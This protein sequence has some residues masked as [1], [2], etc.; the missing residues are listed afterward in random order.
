MHALLPRELLDSRLCA[1]RRAGLRT[2]G[3][4]LRGE[5]FLLAAASQPQGG[6]SAIGAAVVPDYRCGAVPELHRVPSSRPAHAPADQS[7]SDDRVRNRDVSTDA[8]FLREWKAAGHY[9]IVGE[10]ARGRPV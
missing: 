1:G 3:R 5:A 2:F 10:I 9:V 7:H 6:A 8:D 4:V